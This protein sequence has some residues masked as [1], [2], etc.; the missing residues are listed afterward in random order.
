MLKCINGHESALNLRC[1]VCDGEVLYRDACAE[2]VKIPKVEASFED[3]SALYV[4][5]PPLTLPGVYTAKLLVGDREA[6]G[7]ESYTVGK[8]EGG[9]WLDFHEMYSKRFRKWL[10]LVG[11]SKSRYKIV[12]VDTLNPLS[13]LALLALPAEGNTLVFAMTADT[14]S[15]PLEQHTSYVALTATFQRGFPLILATSRYREEASCFTEQEGL[16][17]GE[18]ALALI[19]SSLL[20]HIGDLIDFVQRDARLGV[21]IHAFSALMAASSNVYRTVHDVFLVQHHQASL[22]LQSEE[23]LTVNLMAAAQKDLE[24]PIINGFRKYCSKNFDLISTQYRFYEKHTKFGLYDVVMFYGLKDTKTYAR[25]RKGYDAIA[26][27]A[28]DL[29]VETIS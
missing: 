7:V 5:F 21:K 22:D 26:S 6:E 12:I 19:L 18:R 4:G 20:T 8:F 9:T 27:S 2:L 14:D 10:K 17:L 1:E 24:K 16:T 25:L 28:Q 23:I 11:F 15:T 3:V 29:K 13:V